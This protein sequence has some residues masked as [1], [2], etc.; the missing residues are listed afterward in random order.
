[1]RAETDEGPLKLKD[2]ELRWKKDE[3]GLTGSFLHLELKCPKMATAQR[4]RAGS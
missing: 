1:M 3:A 4:I 2:F